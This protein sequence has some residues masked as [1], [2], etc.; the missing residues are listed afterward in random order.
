MRASRCGYR[1]ALANHAFVWHEGE[2]SFGAADLSRE[3][4]EPINR[5]ILDGRY[6][7]Y[8]AYTS[9]HY[10]AP[11]TIGERLLA[12][13]IPDH[14]GKMGFAFDFSSFTQ[15]RSNASQI[16]RQLL[17]AA[18]QLLGDIFQ[19]CVL[20]SQE[21]FDFFGFGEFDVTRREP[22][23][24]ERYAV[25]FRAG[26]PDDWKQMECFAVK[27][28]I[29][30]FYVL[31]TKS[32]DSPQ[33][34]SQR[35]FNLWQFA[36]Q[37]ADVIAA[38]S[39]ATLE[40]LQIRF[41]IPDLTVALTVL[42]SLD[43]DDYRVAGTDR[44]PPGEG[45][46]LVLDN[47]EQHRQPAADALAAAFPERSVVV[48][49]GEKIVTPIE[50]PN[51]LETSGPPH[52]TETA[53]NLV[54]VSVADIENTEIGVFY[55]DC[56][57]VIVP[58]HSA[59]FGTLVMQALAARRPIFVHAMPAFEEVWHGLERNPNIHFYETTADLIEQLR[60]I[61]QWIDLL[62][63]AGNGDHNPEGE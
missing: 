54:G 60:N 58:A 16:G 51:D 49:G 24:P 32:I 27:A 19:I 29:V 1:V 15:S 10:N 47:S 20:C 42:P 40:Q 9:A 2:Q 36:L 61:P 5:V 55:A 12:E 46:M 4:W 57:V 43:I 33:L 48:L 7:E 17:A 28:A 22:D 41:H 26:Q 50:K 11:E 23:G 44:P 38:S 8:G 52:S 37:Q 62:P 25:I 30:G 39:K 18:G 31:D 59:T 21:I 14:L 56:D 35:R 6:P 34:I 13:L 53:Q 3:H 63:S 45:R